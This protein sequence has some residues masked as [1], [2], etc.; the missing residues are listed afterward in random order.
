MYRTITGSSGS[1]ASRLAQ[2]VRCVSAPT[3]GMLPRNQEA[4]LVATTLGDE[5]AAEAQMEALRD[6]AKNILQRQPIEKPK[7]VLALFKNVQYKKVGG[8]E[9]VGQCMFCKRSVTSTGATRCL[10][11]LVS[12]PLVFPEVKEACMKLRT[13]TAQKR[14]L[15]Q[16]EKSLVLKE[17]EIQQ[18]TL[19]RQKALLEQQGLR[20][21]F[22]TSAAM[23]ADVAIAQFFYANGV[24]FATASKEQNSYYRQMV[25][26]IQA[27]GPAYVPPNCA[28]IAGDLLEHCYSKMQEDIK[29]RDP[30]GLLAD[31]FGVTYTQDGWDS[32]DSLPLINS[33]Y[34]TC[35]DGGVYVRSVDTSGQ[36]KS[37]EYI[38]SLMITDIYSIGCTK[39]VVVVTDTCNTMTKAWSIVED[40][41]PWISCV[42]CVPHVA[43]LLAKDIGKLEEVN[44]LIKE[45]SIIVGWFSHHQKPLAILRSKII[46]TLGKPMQL[47]KAAATRFGTN[48]L[49]GERLLH[50]RAALQQTV[51]DPE[52]TK[53]NYKD[54]D[55]DREESNCEL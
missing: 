16:E 13:Q 52:Y 4:R 31:K 36:T 20:A 41:F 55:D 35:N 7:H 28:R 24:S 46:S 29:G 10:D 50:L 45:E 18:D 32:I 54:K 53:E 49:V 47:I 11:H 23:Q 30:H 3:E 9:L 44:H 37:A 26:A 43:S 25:S 34:I 42:P 38:A 17:A 12:C 27:A 33:A 15:K 51:V 39:V 22:K 40:E 14:K 19:K 1:P 2:L 8:Q 6:E 5:R 21:S 48:T